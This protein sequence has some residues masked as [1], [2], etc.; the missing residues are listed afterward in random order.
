SLYFL[1]PDDDYDDDALVG[2]ETPRAFRRRLTGQVVVKPGY[3]MAPCF[4]VQLF[5][6]I[7]SG[8]GDLTVN[9][10]VSDD[11]GYTYDDMGD[12]TIAS[13]DYAARLNWLSLGSMSAPGRLFRITDTG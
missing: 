8:P 1:S 9:L 4:G 2:N 7:G 10:Q 13:E 6:S 11:R 12:L 3:A 5:G